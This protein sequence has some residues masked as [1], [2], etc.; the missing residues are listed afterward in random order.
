MK[1]TFSLLCLFC[2]LLWGG[3]AH[4]QDASCLTV[5]GSAEVRLEAEYALLSIGVETEHADVALA[6]KENAQRMERVL[7]ALKDAGC[8]EQD[9]ETGQFNIYSSYR[10]DSLPDGTQTASPVYHVS[11]T[12]N[13]TVRNLETAGSLIDRAIEAG[14]NQMNG[15]TFHSGK[16]DSAYT[17]ALTLAC[18]DA[19]AKADTLCAALGLE[20]SGIQSV[21]MP[22]AGAVSPRSYALAAD[23]KGMVEEASTVLLGG[24]ISVSATVEIVFSVR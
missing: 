10:Y 12:L 5:R 17:Q 23:A 3:A 4:A 21:T 9:L 20:I 16:T 7:E 2:L 19:R 14:A 22:Q 6:Q 15:L 18:Q 13:V 8:L 11:N 1:K 24:G